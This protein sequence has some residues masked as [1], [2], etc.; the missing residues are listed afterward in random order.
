MILPFGTQKLAG[1]RQANRLDG[2]VMPTGKEKRMSDI[3]S[4]VQKEVVRLR[5][6]IATIKALMPDRRINFICY[7]LAI[8]AAEKAVREQ[9]AVA[10]CR[11]LPELREME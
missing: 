1:A 10:L 9:D 5:E 11:I 3:S 7:D 4:E 6:L 8:D 2:L